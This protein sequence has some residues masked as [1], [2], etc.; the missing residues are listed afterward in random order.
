MGDAFLSQTV[1]FEIQGSYSGIYLENYNFIKN[2]LSLRVYSTLVY[3]VTK[4]VYGPIFYNMHPTILTTMGM[5]IACA[6]LGP[7]P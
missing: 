7:V 1:S 2:T 5:A 4:P 6:P 3:V